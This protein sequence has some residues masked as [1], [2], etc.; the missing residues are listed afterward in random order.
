ERVEGMSLDALLAGVGRDWPF[1]SFA[2][3]LDAIE[4]RGTAINVGALVG[5]TPVR[6]HVLGDEASEREATAEEV[7]TMRTLVRDALHAGALGFATSKSPTHVGDAGRPVPSRA[8]ARG[9]IET[10]AGTLGEAGHGVMQATIGPGF[11]LDELAAIARATGRPVTWTALLGGML[12][13]DGHRFVLERSAALQAE[14]V[15]VIP[16][17]SCRPLSVGFPL[18]APF[19]LESMSL[20]RPVSQAD[21]AGKRRLYADPDF[22]RALRERSEAGPIAGRF[23]DMQINEHAPDAALRQ[24]R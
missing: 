22:R 14:G 12:G 9:E 16:Q 6:L 1:E 4:A 15:A 20:F 18:K 17:V 8:A 19:P 24:W 10:L 23:A 3:F 7:A 11:F 5:H 21:H 2:E 13:P